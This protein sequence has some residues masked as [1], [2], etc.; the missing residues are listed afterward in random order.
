MNEQLLDYVQK[1]SNKDTKSL[2]EKVLKT[3]EELGE[4]SKKVLPYIGAYGAQH[5]F[6]DQLGVLEESVDVI[7]CALSIAY[8]IG[9]DHAQIEKMMYK[10]ADKWAT[11]QAKSDRLKEADAIPF[12]LHLTLES[13]TDIDK[14]KTVCL[15]TGVKPII[16]EL[17]ADI[18]LDVMTSSRHFGTNQSVMCEMMRIHSALTDN[19]F[20]VIR[21]KVE[22]VTW[23]PMA[24]Q[25]SE[26]M[27][28]GCYFETHI[29]LSITTEQ[30]D[31]LQA[32]VR[33]H[34]AHLSRNKFKT[35]DDTTHVRMCTLRSYTQPLKEFEQCLAALTTA[36][37]DAA[38]EIV[39]VINEFAIYDTNSAHD[40][41]WLAS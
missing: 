26:A 15:Q 29:G 2:S 41:T 40:N 6:S 32:I 25:E 13:V 24:P 10:K 22:T 19:G 31:K 9:F 18:P 14:F 27:P 5:R 37:T 30:L 4:L 12:E 3:A 28:E 20:S 33:E 17:D 38:F 7:L 39:D 11:V 23:H 21:K 16:I 1:L 8:D 35:I 36:L 34:G